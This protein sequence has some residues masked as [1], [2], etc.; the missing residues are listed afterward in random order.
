MFEIIVY[1]RLNQS[2]LEISEDNNIQFKMNVSKLNLNIIENDKKIN[3]NNVDNTHIN[4][5][6]SFLDAN[7]N[8]SISNN[9]NF[10][11]NKSR[12]VYNRSI[13]DRDNNSLNMHINDK[14]NDDYYV[15]KVEYYL[16]TKISSSLDYEYNNPRHHSNNNNNNTDYK[17]PQYVIPDYKECKF[18]IN[19]IYN[20]RKLSY[21]NELLLRKYNNNSIVD[22]LYNYEYI[23]STKTSPKK[24]STDINCIDNDPKSNNNNNNNN[25][26]IIYEDLQNRYSSNMPLLN[27]IKDKLILSNLYIWDGLN[28]YRFEFDCTKK[29]Y[30]NSLTKNTNFKRSFDNKYNFN[31]VKEACYASKFSNNNT[32]I[33][34]DALNIDQN[35]K[36]S[37]DIVINKC[38]SS[39][40]K[41][42]DDINSSDNKLYSSSNSIGNESDS[43]DSIRDKKAINN[44][45]NDISNS[46]EA[47]EINDIINNDNTYTLSKEDLLLRIKASRDYSKSIRCYIIKE[48]NDPREEILTIKII[49]TLSEINK[50]G[51]ELESSNIS[52]GLIVSKDSNSISNFMLKKTKEK[53]KATAPSSFN[54]LKW[55]SLFIVVIL[56][57]YSIIEIVLNYRINSIF[58]INFNAVFF[59]Y[60]ALTELIYST[61]LTRKLVLLKDETLYAQKNDNTINSIKATINLINESTDAQNYLIDRLSTIVKDLSL[62]EDLHKKYFNE[63]SVVLFETNEGTDKQQLIEAMMTMRTNLLNANMDNFLSYYMSNALNNYFLSLFNNANMFTNLVDY[64]SKYYTI[65]FILYYSL[66]FIIS[67]IMIL[68]LV[69]FLNKVENDRTKI[70]FSF[71]EIPVSY[72]NKLTEKCMRYLERYNKENNSDLENENNINNDN[73][74]NIDNDNSDSSSQFNFYNDQNEDL[75]LY[76]RDTKETKRNISKRQLIKSNKVYYLRIC[77]IYFTFFIFFTFNFSKNIIT[78]N[79]LT[80]INNI[81]N[82]TN[83]LEPNF[84]FVYN[85]EIEKI[86]NK[87]ALIKNNKNI[88]QVNSSLNDL[89]V[90]NNELLVKHIYYNKLFSEDYMNMYA[91]FLHYNLCKRKLTQTTYNGFNKIYWN[92]G[93]TSKLTTNGYKTLEVNISSSNIDINDLLYENDKGVYIDR[94][95]CNSLIVNSSM[96][97]FEIS[98]LKY[99]ENLSNIYLKFIKRYDKIDYSNVL[100]SDL[101]QESS[102]LYQYIIRPIS[103]ELTNNMNL[104]ILDYLSEEMNTRLIVFIFFIVYLSLGYLI[105]WLPFQ[106]NL[107]DEIIRTKKMLDVLPSYILDNISS[108]K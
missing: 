84:G 53:I 57:I 5:T 87:E 37:E 94:V 63:D 15:L 51:L 96:F 4:D 73:N 25:Q 50:Y 1:P 7:K 88:K 48:D 24:L 40:E 27:M 21:N 16:N 39:N 56:V 83:Q 42:S 108:L 54:K 22:L 33:N 79:R 81:F 14:K 67:F 104:S 72:L 41:N 103:Q 93:T 17:T 62:V 101:I 8:M 20:D 29:E 102:D 105:F 70:L 95:Y 26:K 36:K 86:I 61:F 23:N 47:E 60:Q 2:I 13:L 19:K 46:K 89:Y 18:T 92:T 91:N 3:F 64:N 28:P 59:S 34:K 85:L 69:K 90:I 12:D 100:R 76:I 80:L 44:I 55:L 58:V 77:F 9:F 43:V 49:E 68:L 38:L 74:N 52:N 32:I 97:G 66:L 78:N 45:K 98:L 71:Y 75:G 107:K 11:D 99:I 82:T 30:N 35:I 31:N 10:E 65:V 6:T 106:Y